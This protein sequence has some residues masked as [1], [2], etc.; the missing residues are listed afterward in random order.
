V[1]RPLGVL[2]VDLDH[3]KA[4]NDRH[5]HLV[6]DELLVSFARRLKLGLPAGAF[7]ARWGGE[8]FA[9]ALPDTTRDQ[10]VSVAERI[11]AAVPMQQTCSVGVAVARPGE[12]EGSVLA[13]ADAALYA[14]KRSGRDR[15][16]AG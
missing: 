7:A 13:R 9:I 3:F 14:A 4:F 6:G 12:A 2:L 8:E 16:E 11:K 10:A 1:E 15:V 5:G